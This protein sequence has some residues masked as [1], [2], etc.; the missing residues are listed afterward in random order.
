M[1]SNCN[2][3]T[4]KKWF[5]LCVN[6]PLS[7]DKDKFHKE[8]YTRL[9][10]NY[11]QEFRYNTFSKTSYYRSLYLDLNSYEF[12]NYLDKITNIDHKKNFN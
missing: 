9:K 10:D 12:Q 11:I 8:F 5:P 1:D 7:V 3:V 4:K 2:K 6:S